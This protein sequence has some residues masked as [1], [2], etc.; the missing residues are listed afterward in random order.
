MLS[1]VWKGGR[2]GEGR[3]AGQFQERDHVCDLPFHHTQHHQTKEL[4]AVGLGDLLVETESRA[5]IGARRKQ[6]PLPSRREDPRGEQRGDVCSPLDPDG[7][8]RHG[9]PGVLSQQRYEGRDVVLFPQIHIA[10]VIC[11]DTCPPRMP[12]GSK[13]DWALYG[14]K[15]RCEFIHWHLSLWSEPHRVFIFDVSANLV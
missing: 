6:A 4:I 2:Q 3:E 5:A 14:K 11:R 15:S 1:H 9:E 13:D 10:V 12:Y 8:R 7:K